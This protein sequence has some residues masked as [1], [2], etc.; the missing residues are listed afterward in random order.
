MGAALNGNAECTDLLLD[1]GADA[2]VKSTEGWTALELARARD[3]R[4]DERVLIVNRLFLAELSY[5]TGNG[6]SDNVRP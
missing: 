1:A 4:D 6:L 2:N 3:E 5:T